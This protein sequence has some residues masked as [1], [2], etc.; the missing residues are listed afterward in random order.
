MGEFEDG[1]KTFIR[2]DMLR[3]SAHISTTFFLSNLSF[4]ITS[5]AHCPVFSTLRKKKICARTFIETSLSTT[6]VFLQYYLLHV[7][8]GQRN[9]PDDLV[10]VCKVLNLI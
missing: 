9:H 10:A 8:Y 1:L 4:T 3:C 7:Q 2:K 5:T 6:K